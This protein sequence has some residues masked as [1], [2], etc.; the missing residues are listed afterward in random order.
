M[1]YPVAQ[2]ISRYLAAAAKEVDADDPQEATRLLKKLRPKRLNPYE[3][4]LVYRMLAHIAYGANESE[5]AIEYFVKFLEEEMLPIRD[6]ARVRF[7]IAQLYASL[8]Q[9]QEAIDW[10]NRWLLYVEEPNPLGFYLMGIAYYQLEEFDDAIAQT[11]RAVEFRPEPLEPGC[12]YSPRCTPRRR[13][14]RTPLRPRGARAALP[15]EA[16]L[17]AALADLRRPRELST[18]AGR[19]A[20]RVRA[21]APH[22]RQGAAATGALLPLSRAALS[23][24]ATVSGERRSKTARSPGTAR[25]SSSSRT[26]GSPP[27]S[28][29]DPS[30]RFG[31]R[32]GAV[33]R[34]E[35]V[36]APGAGAHAARSLERG[37]RAAG[38]GRR[39]GRPEG[40]RQRRAAARHRLL[41]RRPASRARVP[42]LCGRASTTRRETRRIAGSPTST[43]RTTPRPAEATRELRAFCSS[44]LRAGHQSAADCELCSTT[45]CSRAFGSPGRMR[46]LERS[47]RRERAPAPPS[48]ARLE[49]LSPRLQPGRLV[50]LR[51]LCCDTRRSPRRPRFVRQLAR[52]ELDH[53][54]VVE[55]TDARNAVRNEVVRVDEVREGIEN[56]RAIAT[57]RAA[58]RGRAASRS[59]ARASGFARPRS[60]AAS[61]RWLLPPGSSRRGSRPARCSSLSLARTCFKRS[62]KKRMSRGLSSK[63]TFMSIGCLRSRVP[64]CGTASAR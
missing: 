10:L 24:G 53:D 32:G 18:V 22:R 39:E 38:E 34:R 54:G 62:R 13:I 1:R 16:V 57:L 26:A 21:G 20:G 14:T 31:T 11:K 43:P 27:A 8:Q 51:A 23:G 45:I 30:I 61:R 48:H 36:R 4:A 37:V 46:L 25:R 50:R 44:S 55:I 3:R 5:E 12:G 56:A 41:Q 47:P 2:R 35:P 64:H 28:T 52:D 7:N 49:G 15:E 33:G 63:L 6:E 59:A 58:T 60:R 40:S 42:R 17:G 19:A 29:N 9:W